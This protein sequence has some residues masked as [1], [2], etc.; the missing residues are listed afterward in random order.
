M[1]LPVKAGTRAAL[2]AA[3]ALAACSTAPNA[4]EVVRPSTRAQSVTLA[5]I[6]FNKFISDFRATALAA[7]ITPATYD[8]AM[9][10]LRHNT[11]I[12]RLADSQP[13][14]TK[15]IWNYLDTA[16]SP[17]RVADGRRKLAENAGVL[18]SIEAKYGVPREIIVSIWG[19]ETDFG[20]GLGSFNLFEAL[21]TLAYD[22]TRTDF[23]KRELLAALLMAQQE[24]ID[25]KT[26]VASWAGAF[27]QMQMLPSTFLK[28]GADGD[29]DGKRDLWHSTADAL[30]SGAAEVAG[31]GWVRGQP[32]AYE[33]R[34][35]QGFAYEI[36][37]GDVLKP[38]ADWSKLGVRQ[39]DGT[40]LPPNTESAAI[41]LPAGLR[42]PAFMIFTNYRVILKYNNATSYA[43]AIA[44]L[45]DQVAGRR[46]VVAS[47]PRDEQPMSQ[48]ER[49]AF[50]TALQKLGYNFGK[51]DGVLGH[52]TKAALRLY[53]KSRNIPADGFPTMGMLSTLLTDVKQRGL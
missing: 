28:S 36:A 44:T 7:G 23:G 21:A 40:A 1:Q 17:T 47:W 14:F 8:A 25:P 22:G 41:L 46:G 43:I 12:E 27:G 2:L 5:D 52:D 30:A 37:D 6:K 53:Q 11:N 20:R 34:L 26:M 19:N 18:A 31:S 45:A 4:A 39:V 24:R 50:Q 13:E 15:Q 16:V 49:I 3:L 42:G 38:I 9:T 48:A 29:G 35:P 10:G 32:Y 33:V 51:I